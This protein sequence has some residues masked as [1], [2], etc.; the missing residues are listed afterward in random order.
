MRKIHLKNAVLVVLILCSVILAFNTWTDE[1]LW[2]DDY[3]FFSVIKQKLGLSDKYG[4]FGSLSK[5]RL[6]M[7]H[8]IV[9]NNSAKRSVYYQNE[10]G[11]EELFHSVRTVFEKALQTEKYQTVSE[12]KWYSAIKNKSVFVT[13]PAVYDISIIGDIFRIKDPEISV[14]SMKQF[15]ITS[16]SDYDDTLS[17]YIR[18]EKDGSF[19]LCY[20]DYEIAKFLDVVEGSAKDSA[21]ALPYSFELNFDKGGDKKQNTLIGSEVLLNIVPTKHKGIA[22]SNHIVASDGRFRSDVVEKILKCFDYNTSSPR[23]YPDKDDVVYVENYS[24]I[25]FYKS[26]VVEYK[27]IAN[28][29]GISLDVSN[30]DNIREVY[31]A[32]LGFVSKLW[33]TA[34][35]DRELNLMVSS[36]VV[37]LNKNSTFKITMNYYNDGYII[38]DDI[39]MD[40]NNSVMTNAVEMVITSGKIVS[41]RQVM[42]LY[43]ETNE[44]LMN[45]ST[46]DAI[47]ELY[48]NEEFSLGK[49]VVSITPAYTFD[50]NGNCIMT[51]I[52]QDDKKQEFLLKQRG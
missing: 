46:I 26:G 36:D 37:G 20:V 14:G 4:A 44:T 38:R 12:S 10:E 31:S 27:A 13:Y 49:A 17:V 47:D 24:T 45:M 42:K 5:E 3:N 30:K 6:A 51:Y 15:V 40:I 50:E 18:D 21:G 35:P 43:D 41:Y 1:K 25:R 23:K 19:K 8:R 34:V 52:A 39:N 32:S 22:P 2:S 48:Q 28:D 29:K 7:P 11:F 9:V 16:E 33:Q